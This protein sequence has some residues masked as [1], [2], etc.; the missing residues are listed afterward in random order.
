MR[1]A[2]KTGNVKKISEYLIKSDD[3]PALAKG[4]RFEEGEREEALRTT[5]ERK[6]DGDVVVLKG[7]AQAA[8][9]RPNKILK[10]V[11]VLVIAMTET[12]IHSFKNETTKPIN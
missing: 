7:L 2:I 9:K 12:S 4:L 10:F 6:K 11:Q 3:V 1:N 8:L 5:P